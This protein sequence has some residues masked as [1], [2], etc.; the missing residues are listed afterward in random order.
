MQCPKCQSTD[1]LRCSVAH[2]Q[3]TLAGTGF[4][5]KFASRAA[6]PDSG[7]FLTV[8]IVGLAVLIDGFVVG[9]FHYAVRKPMPGW[10]AMALIAFAVYAGWRIVKVVGGLPAHGAAMA[11]W[12]DS[13]ICGRCGAKFVPDAN[14][15]S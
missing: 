2:D 13:W 1:T 5:T 9:F 8:T 7:I 3:G 15:A 14:A 4:E 10:L 12:R 11:R 6:P